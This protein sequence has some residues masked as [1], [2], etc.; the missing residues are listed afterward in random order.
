MGIRI[1]DLDPYGSVNDIKADDDLFEVSKNSGT[2]GFPIYA[3]GD[4][5]KITRKELTSL[6][7]GIH[8]SGKNYEVVLNNGTP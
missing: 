1:N 3:P 8:Y 5:K 6:L 7:G 2:P 4:S